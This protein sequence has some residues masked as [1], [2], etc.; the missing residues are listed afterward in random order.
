MSHGDSAGPPVVDATDRRYGHAK[1]RRDELLSLDGVAEKPDD[2]ITRWDE[3]MDANLAAVI[4]PQ[5]AVV[6]GRRSYEPKHQPGGEIGVHASISVARSLD[7]IH[8]Q[9]LVVVTR[10]A[11]Q[12]HERRSCP[13]RRFP[14]H[15][16][17][18]P[19]HTSPAHRP[20]CPGGHAVPRAGLGSRAGAPTR[21]P[22]CGSP[23]GTGHHAS[24]AHRPV[25]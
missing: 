12:E 14:N 5:D 1:D 21:V 25:W 15:P 20:A 2:F 7:T 10:L 6:L 19:D 22:S 17:T 8:G 4:A 13:R 18:A 23:V 24:P 11:A 9:G 3:A 16:T